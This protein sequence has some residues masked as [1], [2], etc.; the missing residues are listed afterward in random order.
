[1]K[2]IKPYL[3]FVQKNHCTEIIIGFNVIIVNKV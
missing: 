2:R 3:G 1:M